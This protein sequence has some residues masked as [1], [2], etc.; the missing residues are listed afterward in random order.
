M[1]RKKRPSSKMPR[2]SLPGYFKGLSDRL[3]SQ[4]KTMTPVI[5]HSGEMGDNDHLWFADLLRQYLPLR[6]G[7]DTG[8]V[9]NCESDRGSADFFK[10]DAKPRDQDPHIS[11]QMDTLL[12]DVM[13]NA[14]FCVEKTFK[15]CPVEM[16]LGAVEVTR[17]LDKQKLKDDVNKLAKL[18]E[19]AEKK[20]YLNCEF[21]QDQEKREEEDIYYQRPLA[22]V[23]GL[24]GSLS[25]EAVQEVADECEPGR[26]PDIVFLL[27][28]ALYYIRDDGQVMSEVQSDHLYQFIAIVRHRLDLHHCDSVDLSAYLPPDMHHSVKDS[29]TFDDSQAQGGATGS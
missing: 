24:G 15:V 4:V 7:V 22:C 17:D 13:H 8:F 23:V 5:V 18:K 25:K 11:S 14:P 29:G 20:R 3:E 16:V 12:L 19:L 27:N 2:M 26:K 1:A 9:V 28:K 6:Y 21:T 10:A